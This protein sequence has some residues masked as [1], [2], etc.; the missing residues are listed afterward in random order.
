VLAAS[1]PEGYSVHW[2]DGIKQ[3]WHIAKFMFH[4]A[5]IRLTIPEAYAVHKAII[6]WGARFSADRVPGQAVGVDPITERVM[7]RVMA[8]WKRVVFFNTYLFGHLPPRVQLELLPGLRCGAHFSLSAPRPLTSADDY[9]AAGRALQRLWLRATKIGWFIQPE[10]TSLIF[11]RYH[12]HG[13]AFSKLP[14]A[15]ERAE[16]LNS[17]LSKVVGGA[18]IDHIYFIGRI[19]AGPRPMARST[20]KSVDQLLLVLPR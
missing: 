1:L 3:R 2:H 14:A 20:R 18:K 4:A 7:C 12:R 13:V 19:G 17:R 11:S 16:W 15:L 8:N 10:M 5:K 6:E 9:L